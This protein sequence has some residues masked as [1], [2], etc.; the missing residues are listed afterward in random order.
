MTFHLFYRAPPPPFPENSGY[1]APSLQ[2]TS[3]R[4]PGETNGYRSNYP[5]KYP[6]YKPVPPPKAAP[7]K[8]VPPP[9]PKSSSNG[10]EGNYMNNG[11]ATSNSM[12]YHSSNI[13]NGKT[14]Y[15]DF[16]REN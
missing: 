1:R 10:P 16:W 2:D 13:N 12:H 11:Y 8:P 6:D 15:I 7:Y 4:T 14:Y 3:Y 5:M 9:K